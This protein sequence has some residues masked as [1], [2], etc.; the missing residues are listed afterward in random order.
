MFAFCM[1]EGLIT[2]HSFTMFVVKPTI[3]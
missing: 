1:V 3:I 2:D